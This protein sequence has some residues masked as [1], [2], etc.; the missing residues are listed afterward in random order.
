MLTVIVA[1][2]LTVWRLLDLS[3]YQ[4][5]PF[6]T[7]DPT[8][9]VAAAVQ[10]LGYPQHDGGGAGGGSGNDE[11]GVRK[12]QYGLTVPTEADFAQFVASLHNRFLQRLA[13]A[14]CDVSGTGS[15]TSQSFSFH[16]R[17]GNTLGVLDV[18]CCRQDGQFQAF[19]L[20]HEVHAP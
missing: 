3:T 6:L 8:K 1:L 17:Q 20:I 12:F 7:F 11:F 15:H 10:E 9:D 16:Y 13:E 18:D 5:T 19:V 2:M 4:P 14:G